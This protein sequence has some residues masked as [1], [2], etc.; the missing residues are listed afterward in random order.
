MAA[1]AAA[2]EEDDGAR[3]FCAHCE[4]QVPEKN[5]DLHFAHCSKNLQRC[6]ECGE[7]VA[8]SRSQEHFDD[9]HAQVLC[10]LCGASVTRLRLQSHEAQE[11][12][13]RMVECPFCDFPVAARHSA[14]HIDVCG[15]RT[16]WC[17][18]CA[19]YV[20][21]RDWPTHDLQAHRGN[22]SGAMYN[23][24]SSPAKQ[25]GPGPGPQP[26]ARNVHEARR[27]SQEQPEHSAFPWRGVYITLAVA[28]VVSSF[29]LQRPR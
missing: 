22:G 25:A 12:P 9:V 11:C 21:R 6:G 1:A 28:V 3:R 14:D 17:A 16:E 15:S 2:R 18:Q 7:M 23:T 5:Y 10:S 27:R 24:S 13:E 29:L 20:R 19:R 4:K 26:R 8:A